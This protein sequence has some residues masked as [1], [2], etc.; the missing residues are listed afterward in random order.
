MQMGSIRNME[1]YILH[2]DMHPANASDICAQRSIVKFAATVCNWQKTLVKLA[3]VCLEVKQEQKREILGSVYI[4]L[5][6]CVKL[7]DKWINRTAC[8]HSATKSAVP[9]TSRCT[10]LT[11]STPPL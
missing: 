3:P 8:L 11:L 9:L 5:N 7:E 6:F 4:I 1:V 2:V 10:D